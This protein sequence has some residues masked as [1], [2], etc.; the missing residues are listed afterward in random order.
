MKFS[1]KDLKELISN[2]KKD[3]KIIKF[4]KIKTFVNEVYFIET[5]SEEFFLKIFT[6]KNQ[7]YVAKK[8]NIIYNLL[9]KE[10]IKAPKI[11][12]YIDDL[13]IFKFPVLILSKIEG[14]EYINVEKELSKKNKKIIL[15]DL[16]IELG[17][18]HSIIFDKFGDVYSKNKVVPYKELLNN[19]IS[20]AGPF[21]IW[22]QAHKQIRASRYSE[23]K[24]SKIEKLIPP[25]E[26]Y[27]KNNSKLI[28]YKIIPRLLHIDL[29]KKNFL[30]SENKL[31]GII[32]FD[33]A[34]IGHNEEDLMRTQIA[35][36]P[37]NKELKK[38]FFDG[39]NSKIKLDKGY[40]KRL[41]YYYLSR[42]LV[43]MDCVVKFGTSYIKN[44]DKEF[45]KIE[46]DITK[47]LEEE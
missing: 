20:N 17:K 32:D 29:N 44:L 21:K 26:E 22:I 2:Y 9:E 1:K 34:M 35:L 42:Y 41:N 46:K 47:L 31:S 37:K 33:G 27:F 12:T 28:D 23:I 38:A 7:K 4:E 39:Y 36:F 15:K 10:K 25:I 24:N 18:I 40:E 43:Q 19:K 16:G 6:D 45:L 14:T 8:L 11:L 13:K 30:I 3:L 5:N